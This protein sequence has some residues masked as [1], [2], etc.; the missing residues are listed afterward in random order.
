MIYVSKISS[1]KQN[2][3]L[4]LIFSFNFQKGSARKTEYHL[5]IT[6]LTQ[7]P[8]LLSGTLRLLQI[9]RF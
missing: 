4:M 2:N 5:L 8:L 1:L 7:N 3:E 9:Y 6:P